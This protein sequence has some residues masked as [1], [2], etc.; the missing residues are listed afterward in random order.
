M[1][2]GAVMFPTGTYTVT[3]T[4]VGEYT[5]GRYTSGGTSTF[6]IVADVQDVS[7]R[8]LKDLPEGLRA[9]DTK[10]IYTVIELRGL[11]PIR[12]AASGS[13]DPAN[14]PDKIEIEGEMYR[15]HTVQ[16]SR[17]FAKRYRAYC[18][19]IAQ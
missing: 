13:D 5:Q 14:E 17:V 2:F 9:E 4:E 10:V 11:Y 18:E 1:S 3:R 8:V 15:V 19:R 12:P 7:G 6:S 16:K